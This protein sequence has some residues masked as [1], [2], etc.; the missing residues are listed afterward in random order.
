MHSADEGHLEAIFG[1]NSRHALLCGEKLF[2]GA[3]FW[4]CLVPNQH[5]REPRL[6]GQKYQSY[7]GTFG[8]QIDYDECGTMFRITTASRRERPDI[9][10]LIR[11]TA[12]HGVETWLIALVQPCRAPV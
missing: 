6:R 3:F 12:Q 7:L 2:S 11:V 9:S 5:Q 8:L 1:A 4:P 10:S